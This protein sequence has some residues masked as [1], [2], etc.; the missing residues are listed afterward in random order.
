[1]SPKPKHNKS[2]LPPDIEAAVFFMED[3]LMFCQR[4]HGDS[5]KP[6][7]LK[8]LRAALSNVALD[9]G[10]V[11]SG[12]VRCG[13]SAQG[14][15]TVLWI[16]PTRHTL[17][18]VNDKW[19]KEGGRDWRIEAPLP[20]LVLCGH[21]QRYSVFATD[22]ADFSPQARALH[23]PLPNVHPD[24]AVCWGSNRPPDARPGQMPAAWQL[25][26]NSPFNGDL[27]QGKSQSSPDDVRDLLV[28]LSLQSALAYPLDD[29]KPHGQ[30][31]ITQCLRPIL[32]PGDHDDM[33]L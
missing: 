32:S 22:D 17:I 18:L 4:E 3:Q 23:A 14:A 8:T 10:W 25:F 26:M 2:L 9:S 33:D 24:G 7:A 30:S 15:W 28:Q 29:L 16:P 19:R 6:L 1:M 5:L 31:T 21:G 11:P 13:E 12:V 20:G 27:S